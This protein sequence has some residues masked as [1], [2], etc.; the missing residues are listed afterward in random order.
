MNEEVAL[1]EWMPEEAITGDI[2]LSYRTR[3][4]SHPCRV[5]V[6]DSFLR[7]EI[8]AS[9]A[10]FL[11]H[12]AV[13]QPMFALYPTER[14]GAP[15]GFAP[16]ITAEDWESAVEDRRFFRFDQLIDSGGALAESVDAGRYRRLCD[17]LGSGTF[18]SFF[19]G[20]TARKLGKIFLDV[21]RMRE[22]DF[23]GPHTDAR[24]NRSIALL[25]YLARDW[26]ASKGGTLKI[27]NHGDG[28]IDIEP[29]YN[30]LV[31]FDVEAH[32]HHLVTKV[33]PKFTRISLGAWFTKPA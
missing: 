14:G 11:L 12:E 29:I 19:E 15:V 18:R 8:A 13:Y 6:I 25:L 21:H 24:A 5:V 27:L 32:D 10:R 1:S 17:A 7:S 28:D 16:H 9:V 2:V 20:I 30:R 23:I 4:T 22:G 3:F 26:Q 31:L 33:A